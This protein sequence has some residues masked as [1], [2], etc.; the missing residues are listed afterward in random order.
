MAVN[1]GGSNTP[2]CRDRWLVDAHLCD[3]P[4]KRKRAEKAPANT[5]TAALDGWAAA[6]SDDDSAGGSCSGGGAQQDDT[7]T[8]WGPELSTTQGE[9]TPVEANAASTGSPAESSAVNSVP[10]SVDG[11]F[12]ENSDSADDAD[13]TQGAEDG[14]GSS[15]SAEEGE[16][17]V[18][19]SDEDEDGVQVLLFDDD[20]NV[21]NVEGGAMSSDDFDEGE[22]E[23]DDSDIGGAFDSAEQEEEAALR[24]ALAKFMTAQGISGAGGG[25]GGKVEDGSEDGGED[26]GGA[27]WLDGLTGARSKGD[28]KQGKKGNTDNNK[29]KAGGE[30]GEG[31]K[32]AKGNHAK[33]GED[34][35]AGESDGSPTK[36]QK[37]R[38]I[39]QVAARAREDPQAETVDQRELSV[40]VGR[41]QVSSL[42]LLRRRLHV[43][44]SL[45]IATLLYTPWQRLVLLPW[46]KFL[47]HGSWSCS[48]PAKGLC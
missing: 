11:E 30:A 20:G 8:Y 25:A 21:E 37:Q 23:E 36:S 32:R 38:E 40:Y 12:D 48:R 28:A 17:D 14:G 31:G 13:D 27:A 5:D 2:S 34:D 46:Q 29:P 10:K 4:K 45:G 43:C 41:V 7:D 1:S 42:A 39:E 16:D 15:D 44:L 24:S 3:M 33:E 9:D 6:F 22:D 47:L 26:R 18:D 19:D 35:A